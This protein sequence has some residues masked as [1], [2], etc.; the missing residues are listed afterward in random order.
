MKKINFVL[1]AAFLFSACTFLQKDSQK[2]SQKNLQ[3]DSR[4]NSEKYEIKHEQIKAEGKE[5]KY[6]INISYP[7][8]T[9]LNNSSEKGFNT[10]VKQRMEAE[11]DSF[12]VWMKDWEISDYNKDFTSDYDITDTVIYYD[13]KIIS[14]MYDLYYF[15]AGAAHPNNSNFNQ[16]YD[17]ENNK[18]L[19]LNDLLLSGW[20]KTISK[21]CIR[22]ITKHKREL[23]TDPDEWI[24]DG[25]GAVEKNFEVFNITKDSLI[26]TFPTYQV[27]NYI[28]GPTVI[29]IAYSELKNIINTDGQLGRFIK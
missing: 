14:V 21:I 20:P 9:G 25:A 12:V 27:G 15:F 4:K 22:E 5:K 1:I 23:G 8:I 26:I 17:L 6:E 13:T 3:K 24:K 18:P 10:F 19:L 28:E 7:Q 29:S 11:R 2:D 16:N